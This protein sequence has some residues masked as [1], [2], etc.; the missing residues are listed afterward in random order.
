MVVIV[1]R[2][3]MVLFVGCFVGGHVGHSVASGMIDLR[4]GGMQA[5]CGADPTHCQARYVSS[6]AVPLDPATNVSAPAETQL[7]S[8]VVTLQGVLLLW[9][10]IC[11]RMVRTMRYT[12]T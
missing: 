8:G 6:A 5:A 11:E 1:G 12:H 9:R 4:V 2:I 3:S 10:W 7:D